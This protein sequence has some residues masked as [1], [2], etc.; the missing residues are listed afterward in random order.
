VSSSKNGSGKPTVGGRLDHIALDKLR[1]DP[2]NP[3]LP[4]DVRGTTDQ[5]A[6]AAFI[7]RK[8][9]AIEIARSIARNG[10][11]ESEPLIAV[12]DGSTWRVVEG[13]R[14]LTALKGLADESIRKAFTNDAEWD[15][16]ASHANIPTDIPVVVAARERDIWPIIGY[17]HISGI[18]P[19]DPYA[20]AQ[21]IADRVDSNV[22]WND[23]AI[24]VGESETSVR[25]HYRNFKINEQA[26]DDF[27][28]DV[29]EVEGQ[30]GTFTRAMSS[31]PLRAYIKAPAPRDV[32]RGDHPLPKRQ[33]AATEELMSWLFGVDEQEP[34]IDESRDLS[35]LA[36]V[37]ADRKAT[38]V[39]QKTRDLTEAYLISPGQRDDLAKR[40]QKAEALLRTAVAEVRATRS[41]QAIRNWVT[42][43]S[44]ATKAL[45]QAL[46]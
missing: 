38:S 32:K 40:L 34:V 23:V 17:R 39:L 7:A 6:L 24:L 11:F 33:R 29:S 30:F 25:S 37:L 16:V 28:I 4:R 15:Q 27:H 43:C 10:Y 3:R 12:K 26:R 31:V 36:V 13:N 41:D 1:L 22:S 9:H 18:E 45:L 44:K 35:E 8:Y 46:K 20:K 42:R 2:Q 21:F 19:W 14:R 5:T